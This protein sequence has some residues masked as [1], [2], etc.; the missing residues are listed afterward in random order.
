M[1]EGEG[2]AAGYPGF[3]VMRPARLLPN[4][5][6][7]KRIAVAKL[8]GIRMVSASFSGD[9]LLFQPWLTAMIDEG[10]RVSVTGVYRTDSLP[11]QES[12]ETGPTFCLRKSTW[13]RDA[14]LASA[15]KAA[16][17]RSY[18]SS[19]GQV[20]DVFT[21]VN[22]SAGLEVIRDTEAFIAAVNEAELTL[23]AVDR[24]DARWEFVGIKV[25][26]EVRAL[27]VEYSP[28]TT[29][30][31]LIE[32]ALPGWLASVDRAVGVPGFEPDGPL[33]ISIDRSVPELVGQTG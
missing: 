10:P 9:R 30:I 2:S 28:L 23:R 22:R 19:D 7:L 26:G 18:L 1:G 13:L 24:A 16:D 32:S 27:G 29:S 6:T 25:A 15:R 14:D 3:V 5:G 31:D 21:F 33:T 11:G 8:A 20:E 17:L 4:V 12:E